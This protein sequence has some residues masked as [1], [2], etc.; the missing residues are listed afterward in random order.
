MSTAIPPS[1]VFITKL[2]QSETY[3]INEKI[4][5]L[6][7]KT[8]PRLNQLEK[9]IF[10]TH[11]IRLIQIFSKFFHNPHFIDQLFLNN[12]QD[13]FSL[14]VL[15]L[16][17]YDLTKSSVI[18]TFDEIFKLR[19]KT[20]VLTSTYYVDHE[21]LFNS[22]N[23]SNLDIY[24]KASI[25]NIT[26]TLY[27]THCHIMP[28]WINIFPYTLNNYSSSIL[29]KNF[30]YLY[31]K[32][33]FD[34]T[35]LSKDKI[36]DDEFILGYPTLYGC[37][38]NFLFKDIVSIKWM[39]YD[40][41]IGTHLVPNIILLAELL[42]IHTIINTPWY[43]L[44]EDRQQDFTKKWSALTDLT[45]KKYILSIKALVIFYLKWIHDSESMFPNIPTKCLEY[46]H[47]TPGTI[48]GVYDD[49]EECDNIL[50]GNITETYCLGMIFNS[51]KPEEIYKYIYEC[52]HRFHY[53]WYGFVCT[54][55]GKNYI[56]L[57]NWYQFY[58]QKYPNV[59]YH[60]P[61]TT[62][63][64]EFMYY[65]TPKN[66]YNFTKSLI[67]IKSIL[68]NKYTPL[69]VCANWSNM[70][71]KSKEIFV[72][73]LNFED[74]S[75]FNISQNNSRTYKNDPLFKSNG[76]YFDLLKH[77]QRN[78]LKNTV[79]F[80]N[81]IFHT[82]IFNGMLTYYKFNRV[83]TD[84]NLIPNKNTRKAEWAD[85]IL[86]N[87]N[88][89]DYT[90]AYH[91]FSNTKLTNITDYVSIT[92]KSFWYTNFGSNWIAQLQIYHHCKHNRVMYI[93]G[94]TGTGKS[95]LTPFLLVYGIKILNYNNNA[96]VVCTQPR[97]QPVKDNSVQIS[98]NIGYPI[99]IIKS[100]EDMIGTDTSTSTGTNG[101]GEGIRQDVNYIQYKHKNGDLTDE[102][103]H[104]YLR[105]YTDGLLYN[106][107]VQHY[108]Y[109][110]IKAKA[111]DVQWSETNL[112]DIILVDEAH[113]HNVYMDMLLT[114]GK[115]SIYINNSV[116]LGIISATMEED[117]LIYRKYFQI[118]NDDLKAPLNLVSNTQYNDRRLHLSIPFGG[119]NFTV[120]QTFD[121]GTD[122]EEE[123][124]MRFVS[125][126]VAKSN[127][128]DI[129]IF[130]PGEAQIEKLVEKLNLSTPTNTIA[131][132]FYKNLPNDILENVVKKIANPDVR[133]LFRYPKSKYSIVDIFNT[134]SHEMVPVGTYQ[135]FIIVATNIA[136][137]SITIDSLE[138]VIDTGTQKMLI[139]NYDTN[140]EKIQTFM[141]AQP[142][143]KQRI[144]RVGRVKPGHA[145]ATYD[146]SSLS[147]RVIYKI[148]IQN[149]EDF[150]LG[151]VS[152]KTTR[153]IDESND[154]NLV[155][156]IR[157]LSKLPYLFNQ[158][159][160]IDIDN[161]NTA[162]RRIMDL[163][164]IRSHNKNIE[165][166]I[167]PYSDGC[168]SIQTL[169]DPDGKF[170]LIHPNE[171]QFVRDT[172]LRI[173]SYNSNYSNK[174]TKIIHYGKCNGFI[175]ENNVSTPYG[176]LIKNFS[177]YMEF[178]DTAYEF[179]KLILDCLNPQFG[180]GINSSTFDNILLYIIFK[181]IEPRVR[182]HGAICKNSDL[183]VKLSVFPP[184]IFNKTFYVKTTKYV[185]ENNDQTINM[186]LFEKAIGFTVD[187]Y[188][189][190][191]KQFLTLPMFNVVQQFYIMKTKVYLAT[192]NQKYILKSQ[193][194]SVMDTIQE[195]YKPKYE[196]IVKPIV[197]YY[198]GSK[199][200]MNKQGVKKYLEFLE[201][202]ESSNPRF[203]GR[204]IKEINRF[205]EKSIVLAD[206]QNDYQMINLDSNKVYM[207]EFI[208]YIKMKVKD[209][210]IYQMILLMSTEEYLLRK[211]VGTEFY[212]NCMN[213]DINTLYTLGKYTVEY[214]NGKSKSY[215][216]SKVCNDV[217]NQYVISTKLGD[218]LDVKE[219]ISV[220]EYLVD[221]Y[222][223]F[224]GKTQCVGKKIVLEFDEEKCKKVFSKE[225]FNNVIRNMDKITK[226]L[227]QTYQK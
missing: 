10:I 164:T 169:S 92:K 217:Q 11:T 94:A 122:S 46:Y 22:D 24:L 194:K 133:K 158:Y 44:T 21:H 1:N 102:L 212:V 198:A 227:I 109:K 47:L 225:K 67:H 151:L 85:H 166:V 155:T 204:I 9:N 201:L 33:R 103:Y 205:L 98:K 159:T 26:D 186:S 214:S 165:S 138:Y 162:T 130:Q 55:N 117:E 8:F 224:F 54:D 226:F 213:P 216:E 170:Y 167:Y 127:L 96:K 129:L 51:I 179:S 188:F 193:F 104:P 34:P 177:N 57:N 18:T 161:S 200:V 90:E 112:F 74:S 206:T 145:Y 150:V 136:E 75:W 110:K 16:P 36:L 105:L 53:T 181:S 223:K 19:S 49:E 147:P 38:H 132:P 83:L 121:N 222:K 70:S 134:Q 15:L 168:Y 113:E 156:D 56:K 180:I 220:P 65:L 20:A 63:E 125:E 43:S 17:Y 68:D 48:N 58:K 142:N 173:I 211:V 91:P 31:K 84:N 160:W 4:K 153:T 172:K 88:I 39:I 208:E 108:M 52:S 141:I 30:E 111:Q 210:D 23:V 124:I 89:E 28:N 82:L 73:R 178:T 209:E 163:P 2:S 61:D 106:I 71:P 6:I 81:I 182:T 215:L 152:S 171:E 32:K 7:N 128:G 5:Y 79:L 148:N 107:I 93:T 116:S 87:V 123:K 95:T 185:I 120:S 97:T 12:C 115:Y 86:T 3:I 190:Q 78:V 189:K 50:Y 101:I 187:K 143:Y 62:P 184:D 154:P 175:D 60:F 66:I 40:I 221:I 72:S 146:P 29:Y 119:T 137:A 218:D 64:N 37:I 149:I 192:L 80:P 114:L 100:K 191:Y 76:G 157:I 219:M 25:E 69:S 203:V 207:S 118:I 139:F 13:I 27:C 140:T 144:G 99:Q 183:F 42:D 77:Q 196:Q 41:N 131:I 14:I 126:I 176:V 35:T 199:H 202:V 59:V 174:I 135:R 195:Y 45:S 197:D